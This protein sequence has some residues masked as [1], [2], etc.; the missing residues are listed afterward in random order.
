MATKKQYRD[1]VIRVRVRPEEKAK[2]EKLAESRHT[3]ISEII[4]QL[5]HK[6]AESA[7]SVQD[8]AGA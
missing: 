7:L 1:E 3:D 4:R 5:L 8:R 2:F 6:E